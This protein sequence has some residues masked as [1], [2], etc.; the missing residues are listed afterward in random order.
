MKIFLLI[1]ALLFIQIYSADPVTITL[2]LKP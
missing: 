2:L 1:I